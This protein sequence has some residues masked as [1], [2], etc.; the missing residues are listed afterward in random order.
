MNKLFFQEFL[1]HIPEA[2]I[3]LNSDH[4]V[5]FV[6]EKAREFEKVSNQNI[7]LGSRF[8]D[9]ISGGRRDMIAHVLKSVNGN[10]MMQVLESEFKDDTGRSVYYD[11][12]F[13]PVTAEGKLNFICVFLREKTFEKLFEKRATQLLREYSSM[14]ENANAIIFTLDSM[15]Y[16]T[17]W[18]RQCEQVTHLDKNDVFSRKLESFIE[19]SHRTE[20][21]PFIE[22]ILRGEPV[23]S[24][25]LHFQRKDGSI[26]TL[27]L[28]ATPKL[29]AQSKVV[30]IL[31]VGHD[32]TEL[33]AYR[34]SLEEKIAEGTARLKESLD[35][36]KAL[37]DIKN[38]FV[39][40]ASHEFR[41]PLSTISVAVSKMKNNNSDPAVEN[42][43]EI[44]ENQIGHLKG[45]ID[46]VLNVGRTE[47][48]KI[49]ASKTMFNVVGLIETIIG[50]VR[51]SYP[52]HDFRLEASPS[53]QM[54]NSDEKLLRNVFVN[55]I[56]NAAKYS[57][58]ENPVMVSSVASAR[59]I[60]VRVTDQGI[61]IPES[62]MEKIFDS[63]Q[64]GSNVSNIK[65]TGL[66]LS[67]VKR[68]VEA[69]GGNVSV[70]S[71]AGEGS[72]FTVVIPHQ[73]N[74]GQK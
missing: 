4:E 9:I 8:T 32:I 23:S 10:H 59:D 35:K 37:V 41:I 34:R 30:G 70:Q 25:E 39:S 31:F 66:G 21:I 22:R 19:S 1:D 26:L 43:I 16:I 5:V 63:F 52:Q 71:R 55:L 58:P 14:I 24:H 48:A 38:K 47:V 2:M 11:S 20:Y 40:I 60:T 72:T 49:T 45:L 64:R 18:N 13:E 61:G 36:E 12:I 50:E 33:S 54:A 62:D 44:I 74:Q 53:V 56:S 3:V 73:I 42:Q 67:I 65:G 57:S 7:P 69:L 6:N 29:N 28:N 51:A 68:A 27:L 46:D 17:D 15:G